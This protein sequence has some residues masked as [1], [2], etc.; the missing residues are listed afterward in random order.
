MLNKINMYF[1][2]EKRLFIENK[3]KYI[4]LRIIYFSFFLFMFMLPSFSSTSLHSV[5]LLFAAV[6]CVLLFI[7]ILMFGNFFVDKKIIFIVFFCIFCLFSSIIN[8]ISRLEKTPFL[9]SIIFIMIYEFLLQDSQ[10]FISI[11]CMFYGLLFFSLYYFI[12]YF[13]EIITLNFT[14]LGSLFGNENAMSLY[15]HLGIIFGLYIFYK[16]KNYMY[17]LMSLF[18]VALGLTSGSKTYIFGLLLSLLVF[19]I[20]VFGKKKWYISCILIFSGIGILVITI[21]LPGFEIM[22]IRINEFLG[23]LG[24]LNN[25]S[26]DYSSLER[27]NMFITGLNY[28]SKKPIFGYGYEGFAFNSIYLAYSHNTISELLC[29]FGICGFVCFEYPLFNLLSN[30]KSVSKEENVTKYMILISNI[31]FHFTSVLFSSKIFYISLAIMCS[32]DKEEI[33][34]ESN[35]K[36]FYL[37]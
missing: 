35:E 37:N 15:F 14:R 1:N 24:I 9:L 25:G 13:N 23:F 11:K 19:V 7:Y 32:L 8:D 36:L 22:K 27:V 3:I 18:M 21:N 26:R 16:N 12:S 28:F 17:L 29:N 31:F 4:L 34:F 10:R 5:P 6:L 20:F 33:S 2:N 30:K